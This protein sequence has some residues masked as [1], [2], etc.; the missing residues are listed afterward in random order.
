MTLAV[1][2]I[3]VA[4]GSPFGLDQTVTAGIVSA[5]DRPVETTRAAPST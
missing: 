3:A 1:G 2:Q 4:I 5:V